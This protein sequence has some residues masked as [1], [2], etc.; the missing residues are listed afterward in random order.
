MIEA[1]N[2]KSDTQIDCGLYQPTDYLW[3]P[4]VIGGHYIFVL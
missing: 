2:F 4:Y 3:P 1:R